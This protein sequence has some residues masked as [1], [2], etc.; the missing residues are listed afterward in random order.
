MLNLDQNQINALADAVAAKLSGRR[1]SSSPVLS[2][3][4]RAVGSAAGVAKPA[5]SGVAYVTLDQAVGAARVAQ[6]QWIALP[7]ERRK[8]IIR[9]MRVVLRRHVEE[10][11]KLAFEETGLGRYEDK[12]SKNRQRRIHLPPRP[13]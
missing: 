8:E 5:A 9:E 3:G 12:I 1:A 7:M 6:I 2:Y 4:T 13:S 11:S 10:L